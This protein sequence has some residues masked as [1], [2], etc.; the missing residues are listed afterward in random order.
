MLLAE[1]Y[2]TIW[3]ASKKVS[4]V[5][6]STGWDVLIARPASNGNIMRCYHDSFVCADFSSSSSHL[7]I[8]GEC[9][10]KMIREKFLEVTNNFLKTAVNR[11]M[12]Q[13][14][15]WKVL[16]SS[17]ATRHVGGRRYSAGDETKKARSCQMKE[18]KLYFSTDPSLRWMSHLLDSIN[19][20]PLES[21]ETDST[22]RRRL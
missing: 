1:K 16:A 3:V 20:L 18:G 19:Y 22:A 8:Y 15:S 11:N 10:V 5:H 9:V 14:S 4:I 13:N 2:S 7:K 6:R 21:C 17:C 12:V